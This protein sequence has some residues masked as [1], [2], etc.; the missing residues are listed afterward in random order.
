[1]KKYFAVVLAA[2]LAASAFAG[3]N[4]NSGSSTAAST[5]SSGSQQGG[6]SETDSVDTNADNDFGNIDLS[7]HADLVISVYGTSPADMEMINSLAS[8]ITEEKLNC[9]VDLQIM[10]N[11][12]QQY[13]LALSTGEPIDLIWTATWMNCWNYAQQG[14]FQD[15]TDIVNEKFP[16]LKEMIGEDRW[17]A[18]A[19]GGRYYLIPANNKDEA[20]N[21]SQW[22]VIWREDIRK[23]LGCDEIVDLATMEA[24]AEAVI[25]SDLGMI[26]YFDNTSGGLWHMMLEK[27]HIYTEFSSASNPLCLDIDTKEIF[28]YTTLDSV[29]EFCEVQRRWEKNG[30]VQPDIASSTDTGPEGVLSGKYAGAIAGVAASTYVTSYVSPIKA[31]H[32]DWELGYLNYGVMYGTTYENS[33]AMNS[34]AIPKASKNPERALAFIELMI[35][36]NDLYNLYDSGVEGTHY[37]L[38]EDGHYVSL[39]TTAQTY[40]RTSTW[41]PRY[42]I[43]NEAKIYTADEQWATDYIAENMKPNAITNYWANCPFDFSEYSEYTTAIKNVMDQY[44]TPLLLGATDDID[45]TLQQLQ[46]QLE[47]NGMDVV[48]E[49]VQK[50]WDAYMEEKNIK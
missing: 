43:N 21:W 11:P 40:P 3:C 38:D 36:D 37:E 50:Q 9:S 25:E 47:L 10:A 46:K 4:S 23:Q 2:L 12:F 33:P 19:V 20:S 26:P 49:S 24:Y 27:E 41:V 14:A 22:G 16:K 35:I 17:E 18:T 48:T 6:T 44:W 39:Q 13:S 29:R 42:Y 7:K 15:L 5:P 8:E 34:I 32:P 1:M 28:D 30:Y 45:G 31:A